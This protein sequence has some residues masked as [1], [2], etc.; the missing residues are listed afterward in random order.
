MYHQRPLSSPTSC[1]T[2]IISTAAQNWRSS[3]S[4]HVRNQQVNRLHVKRNIKFIEMKIRY[5]FAWQRNRQ[6][7]DRRF[8]S[9]T[10]VLHPVPFQ[11]NPAD[12]QSNVGNR[13]IW[14]VGYNVIWSV[15]RIFCSS[16]RQMSGGNRWREGVSGGC[17][18]WVKG[19]IAVCMSVNMSLCC[20]KWFGST[21]NVTTN[22]LLL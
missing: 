8:P 9:I 21:K 3:Q 6:S 13:K 10:G 2:F 18:V 20:W 4:E 1:Q 19:N 7:I 22:K 12:L 14:H 11:Y 16:F 17:F 5:M 15:Y